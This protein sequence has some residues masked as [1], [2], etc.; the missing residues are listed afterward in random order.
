MG[1]ADPPRRRPLREILR[2]DPAARRRIGEAYAELLAA[3]LVGLAGLSALLIWHL[4]RR[5]RR[6]R[7]QLGPPR[8]VR[9]PEEALPS[10]DADTDAG[11][12][13]GADPT[14]RPTDSMRD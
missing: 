5:G 6:L 12:K 14:P 8:K 10:T 2:A 9:W 4:A 1:N 3:S 11:T 13:A 7:E